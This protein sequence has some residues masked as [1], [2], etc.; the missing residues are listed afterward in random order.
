MKLGVT[1]D[2]AIK[3][4]ISRKKYWRL[5]RTPAMRYAMTNKWLEEQGLFSLKQRWSELAPLR[6]IA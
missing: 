5:S 4:G 3:H 2:L 6:R 1:R